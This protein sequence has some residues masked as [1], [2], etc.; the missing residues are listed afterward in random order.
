MQQK[1]SPD[2]SQE[3]NRLCFRVAVFC[4]SFLPMRPAFAQEAPV[5]TA[6]TFF[7]LAEAAKQPELVYK[8]NLSRKKLDSIP[9][10]IYQML[11]LRVLDLS[12][13]NIDSIAPAIGNLVHLERLNLS[14][15]QLTEL[16]QEIGRLHR[17]RYLSLN[18]NLLVRL[19]ESIG[20]CTA[21][22]VLELWDN[23]LEDVPDNI[24]QLQNLKVLELR[25]ILFSEEQQARIDALVVKS[26][27]I[28]MSPSC[29]CKY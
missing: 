5:D 27:K 16:P 19:P 14:N 13:N 29:N 9:D 12:R 24:S 15:N 3:M 1:S 18:R 17:L 20:D 2:V 22:E 7:S 25:G 6:Y 11:N 8:L 21:L 4:L 28:Y 10:V 23:E 26:A